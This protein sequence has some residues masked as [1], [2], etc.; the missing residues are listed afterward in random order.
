M[1]NLVQYLVADITVTAGKKGRVNVPKMTEGAKNYG[2][3][4]RKWLALD[5]HK[6]KC[7]DLIND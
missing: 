4:V 5:P 7:S 2:T 6:V 1:Y 3:S